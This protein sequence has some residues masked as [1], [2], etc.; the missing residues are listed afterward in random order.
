MAARK[1]TATKAATKRKTATKRKPPA[2]PRKRT[3]A[4]PEPVQRRKRRHW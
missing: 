2:K 4:A 3:V 1:K